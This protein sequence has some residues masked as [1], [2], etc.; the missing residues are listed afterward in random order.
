MKVHAA[1]EPPLKTAQRP[2]VSVMDSPWWSAAGSFLGVFLGFLSARLGELFKAQHERSRLHRRAL[3]RV[4]DS[5][6]EYVND[7]SEMINRAGRARAA[8]QRGELSWIYPYELPI[9][10]TYY[11]D[12]LDSGLVDALIRFN[13]MIARYNRLVVDLRQMSFNLQ[14]AYVAS[15]VPEELWRESLKQR[16]ANLDTIQKFLLVVDDRARDLAVRASLLRS[17]FAGRKARLCR[18]IGILRVWPLK[19]SAVDQERRE[20]DQGIAK[21]GKHAVNEGL[22]KVAS[23][24]NTES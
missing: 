24:D 23:I 15:R 14:D 2:E 8:A 10:R 7:I 11:G 22:A 6:N 9:D 17:Q 19:P 4:Y 18:M 3:G 1:P 16:D 20:F 13:I 21:S 5:A 12:L